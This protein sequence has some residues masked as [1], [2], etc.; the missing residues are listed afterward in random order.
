MF[1][2]AMRVLCLTAITMACTG[3]LIGVKETRTLVLVSPVPIPEAARGTPVV[4]TAEPIDLAIIN[5]PEDRFKQ[6]VQGYV[7]V[8]PWFYDRL[9][10]AW[11]E[12]IAGK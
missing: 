5:R 6:Q 12:K 10:K 1:K 9:I 2:K 7:L 11:N 3:C 4:A 8:D